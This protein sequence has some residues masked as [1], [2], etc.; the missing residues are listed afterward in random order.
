VSQHDLGGGVRRPRPP[1]SHSRIVKRT[2]YLG[3]RKTSVSLE[4]EFLDS[5]KKVA[6]DQGT[7]TSALTLMI[8]KRRRQQAQGG[9]LSSAIRLYVLGYYMKRAEE[10]RRAQQSIPIARA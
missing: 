1:R 7:R 2:I 9:S 3:D 6:A 8:N 5:L 10:A 4:N